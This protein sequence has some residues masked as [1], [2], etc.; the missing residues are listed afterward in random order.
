MPSSP[1]PAPVTMGQ[2]L[3]LSIM[4]FRGERSHYRSDEMIRD[5]RL[6]LDWASANVDPET[7]PS[8]EL[9]E[10]LGGI[11]FVGVVDGVVQTRPAD[12]PLLPYARG[13]V[14]R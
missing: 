12:L 9:E 10:V 3:L 5:R 14:P 7:G 8:D 6:V 11:R 2:Y 13:V 4:A 1:Q